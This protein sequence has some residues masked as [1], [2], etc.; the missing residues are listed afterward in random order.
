MIFRHSFSRHFEKGGCHLIRVQL[1]LDRFNPDLTPDT[2]FGAGGE[3]MLPGRDG[4][5]GRA[6]AAEADGS[7]IVAGFSHERNVLLRLTPAGT[8]DPAFA[9][10]GI[11]T[12][13]AAIQSLFTL[14]D[15]KILAVASSGNDVQLFR[16]T[17]AGVRDATFG[18]G[19]ELDVNLG[20]TVTL[21][22]SLLDPN[23]KLLVSGSA[24]TGA[25]LSNSFT[26]TEGF[27]ARFDVE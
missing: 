7:M 1:V 17:P 23:G 25:P 15:G 3:L 16:Y 5:G 26:P 27:I 24:A 21:G 11:I 6:V 13:R 12:T 2:S 18:V 22:R 19:G 8:L 14:S 4:S 9:G 10:G 20:G